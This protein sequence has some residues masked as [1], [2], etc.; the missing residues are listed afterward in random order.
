MAQPPEIGLRELTCMATA[1]S[2][3]FSGPFSWLSSDPGTSIFEAPI[4]R[5]AGIYLWTVDTQDGHLIYDVGETG[6]EFRQRLRQHLCQQLAGMYHMY[7]PERFAVGQ[8][9]ALWRGMYGNDREAGL[10][11]FVA[12]LPM[13]A[14][15]LANLVR[16]TG[17]HLAP[18]ICDT[19]LRRRI[20]AALA[21]HLHRQ[22]GLVG[23][24]QDVGIRYVPRRVGEEP[25]DVRCQSS[26]VLLGLPAC[27]DV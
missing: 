11:A 19:R 2:L 10:A 17:F 8:T 18:L 22:P 27:L 15:A 16:L 20:E 23:P 1:V 12:R 24:F 3:E 4:A 21:M 13:L 26:A 25:I 9:Y 5:M 14:P 6:T 7:D